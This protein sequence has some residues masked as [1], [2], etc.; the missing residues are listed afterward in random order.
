[1]TPK[2]I[3]K[4]V[5]DKADARFGETIERL[6]LTLR[7][8]HTHQCWRKECFCEY[9]QFINGKYINAKMVLHQLKKRIRYYE[10]HFYL[11]DWENNANMEVELAACRQKMRIRLLKDH[12]KE[13]QK[14]IL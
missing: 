9:C 2:Q 6:L 13:L 8:R 12:K 11:T 14:E 3:L 7:Y 5:Q 1:M 4:E 10:Y